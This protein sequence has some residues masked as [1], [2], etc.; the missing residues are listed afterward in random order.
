MCCDQEMYVLKE[1]SERRLF[2]R[3]LTLLV[4]VRIPVLSRLRS[5]R[6]HL[7]DELAHRCNMPRGP[8]LHAGFILLRR[9]LQACQE[10][11]VYEPFPK[12]R[13]DSFYG[14]PDSE[15]LAAGLK[16]KFFVKQTVVQQRTGL[17]PIAQNHHRRYAPSV[18]GAAM[19]MGRLS[20]P[21]CNSLKTSR[22][23]VAGVP[24]G[25]CRRPEG[26]A[27]LARG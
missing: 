15:K 19:R 1:V 5:L 14:L 8:A 6:P 18:P 17:F 13:H 20:S 4:C 11:L 27:V 25:E 16:K 22:G 7:L 21:R 26:E 3:R 12:C 23:P 9:L 10:L 24:H 2:E